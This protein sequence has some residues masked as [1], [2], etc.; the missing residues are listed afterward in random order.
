MENRQIERFHDER[1]QLSLALLVVNLVK[2]FQRFWIRQK[3]VEHFIVRTGIRSTEEKLMQH[4]LHRIRHFL[5]RRRQ[6]HNERLLVVL[7][8][9]ADRLPVA[10][11]QQKRRNADSSLELLHVQN[12]LGR[13]DLHR[14][15]LRKQIRLQHRLRFAHQK[16][17]EGR[18]RLQNSQVQ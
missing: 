6:Q 5:L 12:H 9:R 2:P 17:I 16:L 4:C 1:N 15:V 10:P 11:Q 18:I 8:K 7:Q 13:F 3:R 14:R